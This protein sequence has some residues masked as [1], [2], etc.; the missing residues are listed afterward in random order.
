MLGSWLILAIVLVDDTL[1]KSRCL[2]CLLH[3]RN[4]QPLQD[5]VARSADQFASVWARGILLLRSAVSG[6]ALSF[7]AAH[8]LRRLLLVNSITVSIGGNN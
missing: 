1:R 5:F 4:P 3:E 8:D 2:A 6:F 7:R